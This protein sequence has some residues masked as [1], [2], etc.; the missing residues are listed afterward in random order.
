[1][2]ILNKAIGEANA[3]FDDSNGTDNLRTILTSL[4][5]TS[6][7]LL[8]ATVA[9]P[10]V[11][12]AATQVVLEDCYIQK[13]RASLGTTGTV[14]STTVQLKNGSTVI[15]SLTFAPTDADGIIKEITV[16]ESYQ[17]VSAGATITIAVS[18]IST[19]PAALD[20]QAYLQSVKVA[21]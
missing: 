15:A 19:G 18:A 2:S 21:A 7:L 6:G 5:Y 14:T 17:A 1:M 16:A 20:A 4:A 13:F 9:S 10:T 12:T 3:L 11:A 8:K